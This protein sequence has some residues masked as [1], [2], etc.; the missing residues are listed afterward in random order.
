MT[1]CCG[2]PFESAV[3]RQF[4]DRIAARELVQ[5][6]RKG[7]AKTARLLLEGVARS[8][9]AADTV[10]DIGAGIGA[11]TFALLDRGATS[12][13]IV[14]ASTAYL[15]AAR[16][17][18]SRRGRSQSIR[19]LQGDFVAAGPQLPAASVVMLDRVVCCYPSCED[20]LGAACDRAELCLALSYPRDTWYVRAANRLGNGLRRLRRNPFRTFVHPLADLEA[21]LRS[22]GF[23][24]V[25][26]G[27]TLVW[28][29]DVWRAGL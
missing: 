25:S 10:I 5:Y 1:G 4:D 6:R 19:F 18:A 3:D 9:A 21:I 8:A 27:K 16:G 2:S 7:P 26:R 11:L 15:Q 29:A 13:V 20:L 23:E 28:S 17:E 14:D 12:A 22:R 24:L